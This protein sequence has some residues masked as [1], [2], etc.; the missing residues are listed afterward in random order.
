M[1]TAR[2][3]MATHE[4]QRATRGRECNGDEIADQFGTQHCPSAGNVAGCRRRRRRVLLTTKCRRPID[5]GSRARWTASSGHALARLDVGLLIACGS[6]D[7]HRCGSPP[8]DCLGGACL[9][10][11]CL[12]WRLT[13]SPDFPTALTVDGDD[14]DWVTQSGDLFSVSKA[15]GP[16]TD[17]MHVTR[18]AVA[19]AASPSSI[20]VGS[21][22][23]SRSGH[24]CF[25]ARDQ[26]NE[27]RWHLH[28]AFVFLGMRPS[29]A[30]G[31]WQRCL[32]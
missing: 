14:I 5:H 25:R 21:S 13:T 12:A 16:S 26:I 8:V 7:A 6:E 2:A 1:G 18:Y 11:E 27:A 10:G 19:V 30:L 23:E 22:P 3:K 24:A 29:R 32:E 17:I 4:V 31:R 20:Y 28:I 9:N 15:G